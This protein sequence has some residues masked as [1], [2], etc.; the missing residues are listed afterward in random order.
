MG[1]F[2]SSLGSLELGF[3]EFTD[4]VL[5]ARIGCGDKLKGSVGGSRRWVYLTSVQM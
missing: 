1:F 5:R 4:A 2:W 3:F